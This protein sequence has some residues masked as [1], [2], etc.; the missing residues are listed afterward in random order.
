MEVLKLNINDIKDSDIEF[1]KTNYPTRYKKACEY[2]IKEDY[3]RSIGA[4]ILIERAF[5][6]YKD[7]DLFL[8]NFGKPKITGEVDF[9]ISHS[10]DVVVLVKGEKEELVGVDIEKIDNKNLKIMYKAFSKSEIDFIN[11]DKLTN[12]HI[13]WTLKEASLKCIGIGLTLFPNKFSVLNLL[14]NES[15]MIQGVKLFGKTIIDKEYVIGIV[16]TKKLD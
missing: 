15:I 1:I 11:E 3:L 8:E 14:N 7:S 2:K 16:S 4:S 6:S 5:P 10:G 13:L 9:N 12:F